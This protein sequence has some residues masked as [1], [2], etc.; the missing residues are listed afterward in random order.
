M[1]T[2]LT[3]LILIVLAACGANFASAAPAAAAGT[4]KSGP[5]VE[6]RDTKANPDRWKK[7]EDANPSSDDD[8]ASKH[9]DKDKQEPA[10]TKPPQHRG[11]L[12]GKLDLGSW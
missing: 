10:D 9:H 2:R 12:N 4:A 1:S 3:S 11:E 6:A 8:Q 5:A 7:G